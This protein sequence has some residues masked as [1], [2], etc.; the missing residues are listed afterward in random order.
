MTTTTKEM[1]T[2]EFDQN[3]P[4]GQAL[5][6]A[7]EKMRSGWLDSAEGGSVSWKRHAWQLASDLESDIAALRRSQ[8]TP[9]E[10]MLFS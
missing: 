1:L 2:I 8:R 4:T 7:L 5:I 9:E 6:E 3:P 10:P